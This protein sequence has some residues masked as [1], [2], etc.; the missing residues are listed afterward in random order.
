MMWYNGLTMA[1]IINYVTIWYPGNLAGVITSKLLLKKS[2]NMCKASPD[3]THMCNL[4][5][6]KTRK[7]FMMHCTTIQVNINGNF[8]ASTKNFF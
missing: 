6:S 3:Q 7:S 2:K 8:H 1:S 5:A 4:A